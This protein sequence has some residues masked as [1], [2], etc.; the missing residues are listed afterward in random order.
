MFKYDSYSHENEIRFLYSLI[1]DE[2]GAIK[3]EV[4]TV[5]GSKEEKTL[6]IL[7]V[8]AKVAFEYLDIGHLVSSET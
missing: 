5:G 2:I 3:G 4:K 1:G 6:P 8:S 7:S